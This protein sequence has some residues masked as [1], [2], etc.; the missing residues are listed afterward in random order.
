MNYPDRP[1]S[2]LPGPRL[3]R[4]GLPGSVSERASDV[5]TA[6]P[7]SAGSFP[8]RA[9]RR[10]PLRPI[11]HSTTTDGARSVSRSNTAEGVPGIVLL[12]PT[13]GVLTVPIH[14]TIHDD[15]VDES[16]SDLFAHQKSE[17]S[18]DAVSPPDSPVL[19]TSV[20]SPALVEGGA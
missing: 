12:T 4:A 10:V 15:G 17:I 9:V 20:G 16:Q 3:L 6:A 13:A 8:S 7:D 11:G 14:I 18:E 5:D 2:G 1:R 19:L